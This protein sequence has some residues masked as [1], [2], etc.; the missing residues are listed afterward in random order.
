MKKNILLSFALMASAFV[1]LSP[2]RAHA[3]I[4]TLRIGFNASDLSQTQYVYALNLLQKEGDILGV[5]IFA[6]DGKGS[7]SQQTGDLMNTVNMGLDGVIL[8]PNDDKA[9]SATVSDVLAANMPIVT[10]VNRLNGVGKPLYQLGDNSG[11][12][13]LNEQSKQALIA[14][15]SFIRD[16]KPLQTTQAK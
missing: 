6:Q 1:L 14:L 15:V 9:L 11:T 16:K 4:K 13:G 12:L 10:I 7:V 5:T 2:Q 3:Q 8:V